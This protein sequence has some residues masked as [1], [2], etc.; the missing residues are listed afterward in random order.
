VLWW[1]ALI[2]CFRAVD[3]MVETIRLIL[4]VNGH[5]WIASA[6]AAVEVSLWCWIF[7]EGVN[8]HKHWIIY[9]AYGLGF[10]LGQL[11]GCGLGHKLNEKLKVKGDGK[12]K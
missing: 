11:V 2:F 3:V 1:A 7:S 4:V 5:K 8:T 9:I 10:S 12:T 6:I